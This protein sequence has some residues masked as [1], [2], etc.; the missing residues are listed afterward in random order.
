[1]CRIEPDEPVVLLA[2]L[3]QNVLVVHPAST[4][5]G[6]LAHHHSRLEG[7]RDDR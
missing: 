3:P 6:L 1:M 5:T 4:V 7:G 2:S